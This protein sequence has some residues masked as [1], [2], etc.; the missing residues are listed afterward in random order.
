MD[1]VVERN[2]LLIFEIRLLYYFSLFAS[3]PTSDLEFKSDNVMRGLLLVSSNNVVWEGASF[4]WGKG[5]AA[6]V[7]LSCGIE[8]IKQEIRFT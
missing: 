5:S 1:A 8:C 2:C 6:P 7:S 3:F 4:F